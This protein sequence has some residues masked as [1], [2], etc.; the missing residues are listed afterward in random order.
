MKVYLLL[1]SVAI[2]I[3]FGL[4][5]CNNTEPIKDTDIAAQYNVLKDENL[6]LY[7][8]ITSL[9][10]LLSQLIHFNDAQAASDEQF[11]EVKSIKVALLNT[12]QAIPD[13]A[14]LGGKMTFQEIKV[15][16][17]EWIFASYTDG[18]ITNDVIFSY[19]KNKNNT[20]AFNLLLKL[21]KP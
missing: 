21:K 17:D 7:D 2:G 1:S 3:A 10:A 19:K 9:H 18:H 20:Y 11:D 12:P 14:I 5:G 4:L 6:V 16:N 8:S 15:L 13:S